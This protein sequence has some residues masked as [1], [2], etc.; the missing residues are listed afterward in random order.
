MRW[1][2]PFARKIGTQEGAGEKKKKR[3]Q[4]EEKMCN[5]QSVMHVDVAVTLALTS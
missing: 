2:D 1:K 3:H 5:V 4:E